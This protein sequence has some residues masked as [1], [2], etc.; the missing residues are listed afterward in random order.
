[1]Q[2]H[3]SLFRKLIDITSR[4]KTAIYDGDAEAIKLLAREHNCVMDKLNRAGFSKDTD[5]F[6]L[7][8]E[9]NN[10]VGGIIGEIRKRRDEISR[11]LR[12]CVERKKMAG[13][14]AKNAGPARF[15]H[16]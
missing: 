13:A 8:R 12:T 9:A 6:D 7:V 2:L 10:Q 11:G 4:V 15:L 14:Y 16:H 5:L 3:E 1:M